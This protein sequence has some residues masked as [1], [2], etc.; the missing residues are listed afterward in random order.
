VKFYCLADE[1]TVRGFALAGV[2]GRAVAEPQA[3]A[4][5]L[6]QACA[7]KDIGIIVMTDVVAQGIRPK[8]DSIR[9]GRITPLIV[10]IPGPKGPMP[11]RK[12]LRQS[13]Q[14]AI[15]IRLGQDVEDEA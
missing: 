2:E 6:D 15:G 8:I 9:S 13:V 14:E 5:A 4:E 11:G 1:D 3:A 7:R 10:E 12:S